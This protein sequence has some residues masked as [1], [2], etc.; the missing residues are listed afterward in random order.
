MLKRYEKQ[1]PLSQKDQNLTEKSAIN[2][3]VLLKKLEMV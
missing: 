3:H 1:I 2:A